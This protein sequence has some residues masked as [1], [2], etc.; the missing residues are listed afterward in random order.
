MGANTGDSSGAT[1][2]EDAVEP[3]GI[4]ANQEFAVPGNITT[5]AGYKELTTTTSKIM[6]TVII[7]TFASD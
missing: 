7:F 4:P 6:R 2:P 3:G 1:S 5:A